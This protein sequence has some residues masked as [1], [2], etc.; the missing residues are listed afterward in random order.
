M[1]AVCFLFARNL[2]SL[3]TKEGRSPT[4]IGLVSSEWGG[5][6][7]Q[8]WCPQQVLDQCE[9]HLNLSK[10]KLKNTPQHTEQSLWNGM[11]NPL[12]RTSVKGFLWYQG[13]RNAN[14][15]YNRDHYQCTFPAMIA[16]WRREFSKYSST[17]PD[18]PFGFVQLG[19]IVYL[20]FPLKMFLFSFRIF[21]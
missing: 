7:I 13:E 14:A 5:S 4:P 16:A 6:P 21:L 15:A 11:I 20:G 12:K 17:S 10:Q 1:S 19:V 3:L 9:D 18:A 8:S 2:Q